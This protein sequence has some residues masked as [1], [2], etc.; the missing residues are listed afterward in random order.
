VEKDYFGL[1]SLISEKPAKLEV[2]SEE[3]T[4]IY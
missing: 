1:E 4:V 2:N 3:F